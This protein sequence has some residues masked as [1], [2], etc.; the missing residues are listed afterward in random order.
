MTPPQKKV[1]VRPYDPLWVVGFET[2][3]AY[4]APALA[5]VDHRVEHVGSTAVPGLCAKPVIDVDV[6][7][8]DADLRQSVRCLQGLGYEYRGDLG[9]P[10]RH[11][12]KKMGPVTLP[13]HNL[14]VVVEGCDALTNHLL[15][16]NHLRRRPDL[17]KAYGELK[18]ELAARHPFDIDAYVT[19]KTEF[20]VAI[21]ADLGMKEAALNDIRRVNGLS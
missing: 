20:I 2:I 1:V 6:V 21:L 8:D 5:A 10:G 14:Y 13:T 3:S 12:M 7:I 16:R 9:I 4:V 17:V 11:A 15:L 19:G 18:M